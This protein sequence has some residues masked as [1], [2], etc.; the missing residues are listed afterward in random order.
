M[1]KNKLNIMKSHFFAF[2]IVVFLL[3]ASVLTGCAGDNEDIGNPPVIT[4]GGYL[5]IPFS[6][7]SEIVAFFPA[8]VNGT[9]ME[10]VVV[11]AS[12]G[13]IRTAFNTCEN[14]HRSGRGYYIQEG[15][16]LICQQCQMAFELDMVGLISGGCQPIPIFENSRTYSNNYIEI[17]YQFLSENTHWF[18]QWRN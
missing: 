9:L 5:R 4:S 17:S 7:V 1:E 12:D 18:L 14:C 2:M 3:L 13:T 8:I 11:Q 16:A 10:V 15:N 6:S